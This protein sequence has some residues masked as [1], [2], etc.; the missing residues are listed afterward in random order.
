MSSTRHGIWLRFVRSLAGTSRFDMFL[1]PRLRESSDP[2]LVVRAKLLAI[3]GSMSLL[4]APFIAGPYFQIGEVML[5][6]YTLGF[7]LMIA[8]NALMIRLRGS[9]WLATAMVCLGFWGAIITGY[10]VLGGLGSAMG[11]WMMIIPMVGLFFGG[12]R[13]GVSWLIVCLASFVG[14]AGLEISGVIHTVTVFEPE[15]H[16]LF[17]TNNIVVYG[18]LGWM[19]AVTTEAVRAVLVERARRD[20]RRFKTVLQAAADSIIALD[21]DGHVVLANQRAREVFSSVSAAA[22]LAKPTDEW[23]EFEGRAFAVSVADVEEDDVQKIAILR[24]ETSRRDAAV[25][26]REARDQA[27]AANLAKSRFLMNMS[28]E[29]RTPLNAIIGYTD[30]VLEEMEDDGMT[31]YNAELFAVREASKHLVEIVA[32][33]LEISK[34][35]SG[36]APLLVST[37]RVGGFLDGLLPT[38]RVLVEQTGSIFEVIVSAD[39]RELELETDTGKLRRVL[40]NLLSNAAKFT[41]RG[42]VEL[43]LEHDAERDVVRWI[44][45]DDGVGI[46]PEVQQRMW[47]LFSQGDE[48]PS[49][50][51][52]GLGLGLSLVLGISRLLGGRVTLE[53]EIGEGATFTVEL[54][55]VMVVEGGD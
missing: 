2:L 49:R 52:Q 43:E 10:A 12:I 26:L 42:R 4:L 44:V 8:G 22:A 6:A 24:D 21:A 18:I 1:H 14:L 3:T 51:H 7:A 34:I 9:V 40:L 46:A 16:R 25:A 54:P 50:Q 48:S 11:Y 28:H 45:R 39:V 38:V 35:E 15:M 13:H 53:S 29:L 37:E 20:E 55:R 41:E 30:L 47:E 23:I 33:I 31:T 32:D 19:I 36:Q 27:E 17:T 5:G